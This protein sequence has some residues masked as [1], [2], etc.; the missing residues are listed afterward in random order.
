ME[1]DVVCPG[2]R[3]L[4]PS[5]DVL[6]SHLNTPGATCILT[7]ENS[8]NQSIQ[9]PIPPSLRWGVGETNVMGQYHKY[10]GSIFGKGETLLD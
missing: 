3:S 4:F 7:L 9:V 6:M 10:S 5:P 8:F 1:I 2:C